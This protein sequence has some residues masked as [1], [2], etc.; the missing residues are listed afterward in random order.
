MKA[1]TE[2]TSENDKKELAIVLEKI[3]NCNVIAE[4]ERVVVA[5][6][7]TPHIMKE[8][9]GYVKENNVILD[10]N[11]TDGLAYLTIKTKDK[12]GLEKLKMFWEKLRS[13][14]TQAFLNN[15]ESDNI[16]RI[17]IICDEIDTHEIVYAVQVVNPIFVSN[18]SEK[19]D[20]MATADNVG[21]EIKTVSKAAVDYAVMMRQEMEESE[22][23]QKN[24]WN[25]D[26]VSDYVGASVP[27]MN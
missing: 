8:S 1:L 27:F 20:M 5:P 11:P 23:Q 24:N 6:D 26:D 15:K 2:M 19:M 25:N 10:I 21:F 3:K 9:E 22:E 12:A 4:F 18:E 13:K 17:S 16:L 14:A 7:G